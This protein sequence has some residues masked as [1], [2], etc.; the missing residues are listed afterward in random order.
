M[1]RRF[2]SRRWRQVLGFA[3]W[4]AAAVATPPAT[5]TA[6]NVGN[7]VTFEVLP[8]AITTP[9]DNAPLA[10]NAE[11][12]LNNGVRLRFAFL[13]VASGQFT[14][15]GHFEAWSGVDDV[16]G[17]QSM[18]G[19]R[20]DDSGRADVNSLLGSYF[21]R[22]QGDI[23]QR[24]GVVTLRIDYANNL[25]MRYAAG[26]IWDIDSGNSGTEQWDVKAYNAANAVIGS[27]LSPLGLTE[28]QGDVTPDLLLDSRPWVFALHTEDD[29]HHVVINFIGTKQNGLGLA[30]NNFT[31][32]IVPEPATLVTALLAFAWLLVGR[33]RGMLSRGSG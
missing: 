9:S 4:A 28:E 17:F 33:M 30:F 11:Y 26:E 18:H 24:G 15:P 20:N 27:Q 10:V 1:I 5:S 2:E 21:F 13:D 16:S 3:A 31:T 25:G 23:S 7:S 29:I 19:I 22:S 6:A 32:S 12:E 8:D 14:D